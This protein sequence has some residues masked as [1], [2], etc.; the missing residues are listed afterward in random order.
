MAA[1]TDRDERV[2]AAVSRAAD[3][4]AGRLERVAARVLDRDDAVTDLLR[5]AGET[6]EAWR[7]VHDACDRRGGDPFNAL[8]L[9][10]RSASWS[11]CGVVSRGR[12]LGRLDR[13]ATTLPGRDRRRSATER[14]AWDQVFGRGGGPFAVADVVGR[15]RRVSPLL[16]IGSSASALGIR[17]AA[18]RASTQQ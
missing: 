16:L 17:P 4:R 18:A 5:A 6:Y 7:R 3:R 13:G 14:S 1:L 8:D 11:W 9:V 12:G 10:V 2:L 15:Q